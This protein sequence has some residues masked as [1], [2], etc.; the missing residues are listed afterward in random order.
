MPIDML[1]KFYD[2]TFNS[3]DSVTIIWHGG[4]PLTMGIQF[5]R[6]A[7]KLQKRYDKVKI[8]NRIQTN[9]SLI[10][11]EWVQFFKENSFTIGSSFDGTINDS[12]RGNS[13]KV[14]NNSKLLKENGFNIGFISV[15]SSKN[16]DCLIDDYNYFKSRK[17][18]YTT[19][20]YLSPLDDDELRLDPNIAINS[21][22]ELFEYWVYDVGSDVGIRYFETFVDFFL[23]KKKNVCTLN[24]CLGHWI[25]V[26]ANGDIV[27]CNRS[28]PD[29]FKYGNINEMNNIM[30]AFNSTGFRNILVKAIERRE[31]C[32]DCYAFEMCSGGCNNVA[33]CE[34]GIENNN[35][36]HCKIFKAIYNHI[37]I[38]LKEIMECDD[39]S[40]L[41]KFLEQNLKEYIEKTENR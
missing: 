21:F 39:F 10:D 28:F 32:K 34:G 25:G 33:L 12:T 18:N 38:R 5:F 40:L 9:L 36:D 3:M 7:I 6:D 30:D 16:I 35:G 14:L 20:L 13:E 17:I 27:P 1:E 2:I 24:S 19:N 15:I 26:R 11:S 41:N 37:K 29:E 4:E 23:W 22:I 8:I 31:K